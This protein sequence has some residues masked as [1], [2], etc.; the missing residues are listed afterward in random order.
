M[1]DDIK[2]TTSVD[3]N[4]KSEEELLQAIMEISRFHEKHLSGIDVRVTQQ[5]V[6]ENSEVSFVI[7]AMK[8]QLN[9]LKNTIR[10]ERK[11]GKK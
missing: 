6:L 4:G 10:K 9:D 3:I 8:D 1:I 7:G 5:V 11:N 2:H